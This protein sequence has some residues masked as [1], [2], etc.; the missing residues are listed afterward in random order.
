MNN[1]LFNLQI[2]THISHSPVF[3]IPKS[4]I[5]SHQAIEKS[6]FSKSISPIIFSSHPQFHL[7][8]STNKFQRILS[9]SILLD[10]ISL[11]NYV[12]HFSSE[13]IDPEVNISSC[14]FED[15]IS[16]QNGGGIS[17][18]ANTG[19]VLSIV[20]SIFNNNIAQINGG[21]IYFQGTS[22][23]LLRNC[24]I[25]C[26][27]DQEG[28]A[29]KITVRSDFSN[30]C[31]DSTF[32]ECAQKPK[33]RCS[34]GSLVDGGSANFHYNNYTLNQVERRSSTIGTT[35]CHTKFL[36]HTLFSNNSGQSLIDFQFS[37]GD[38]EIYRCN[39]LHNRA[40]IGS[41]IDYSTQ[42]YVTDCFFLNNSIPITRASN[43]GV[44]HSIIFKD[45]V[46]DKLGI[47]DQEGIGI[48]DCRDLFQDTTIPIEKRASNVCFH[49]Q[50]K[51]PSLFVPID[52]FFIVGT[53]LAIVFSHIFIIRT[54][55][56]IN[57][58]NILFCD[59]REKKK[60]RMRRIEGTRLN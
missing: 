58:F 13:L 35:L 29:Y 52:W 26:Q 34:C 21:G 27:A 57:F 33:I 6:L 59:S 48:N 8:V 23:K 32:Y 49:I 43:A 11:Q 47:R 42:T 4:L 24:F 2:L 40:F 18:S 60:R 51:V 28:Q 1:S 56:F 9:S 15:C 30:D 3:S 55:I 22:Y 19:G 38:L 39:F 5:F 37:N 44:V 41:I 54:S 12:R 7:S 16:L 46:S 25:I 50:G 45:C 17:Y 31:N 10:E 20:D 36:T 53:S 14:L